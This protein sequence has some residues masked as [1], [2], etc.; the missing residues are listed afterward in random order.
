MADEGS[1][2][3]ERI[4]QGQATGRGRQ[5]RRSRLLRSGT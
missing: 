2:G 4:A 1:D 5:A 3:Y